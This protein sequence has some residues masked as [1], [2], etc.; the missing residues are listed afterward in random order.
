MIILR[1]RFVSAAPEGADATRVRASNWNDGEVFSGGNKGSIAVRDT[2]DAIYGSNW[3]PSVAA[4]QVLASAG[5]GAL[6]AWTATPTVDSINLA[7]APGVL[8]LASNLVVDTFLL[9]QAAN[10]R[11][12]RNGLNAQIFQLYNSYAGGGTD[13]ERLLLGFSG[14]LGQLNVQA[15]GTGV[16]RE[17]AFYAAQVRLGTG[18]TDRWAVQPAG[19]FVTFLDNTYDIGATVAANRPRSG[20]FGTS[21]FAPVFHLTDGVA[22]PG[23][24]VGQ[25][26]IYVDVA[27]GDLK[28][29]FGDGV[30]KTIVTDV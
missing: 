11:A 10:T 23:A 27:D 16:Q 19:H 30:V 2:D 21:V 29:V 6:P 26:K 15:S 3:V 28:V 13:T 7:G 17:F 5:V 25:A 14:N 20:F 12:L 18:V 8:G 1:H 24:T 9:S 4:G 22:A